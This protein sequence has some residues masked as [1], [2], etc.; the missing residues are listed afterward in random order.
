MRKQ[1][2]KQWR[3]E[4]SAA[5]QSSNEWVEKDGLPLAGRVAK[6]VEI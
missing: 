6:L 4:N 2:A 1:K 3:D 5:I